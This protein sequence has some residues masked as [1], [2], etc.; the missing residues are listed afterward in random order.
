MC[1]PGART[2]E[3]SA[4]RDVPKRKGNSAIA[5]GD[6]PRALDWVENHAVPTAKETPTLK[7]VTAKVAEYAGAVMA[8]GSVG[9]S[10]CSDTSAPN[11]STYGYGGFRVLEAEKPTVIEK[12]I[13]AEKPQEA[14]TTAPASVITRAHGESPEEK[15]ARE[16]REEN[17]R[18]A[19]QKLDIAKAAAAAKERREAIRAGLPIPG[20]SSTPETAQTAERQTTATSR[21]QEGIKLSRDAERILEGV[22]HDIIRIL[23]G[24]DNRVIGAD[25]V[26]GIVAGKIRYQ[27]NRILPADAKLKIEKMDSSKRGSDVYA[28]VTETYTALKNVF[29]NSIEPVP[30]W[31][32]DPKTSGGSAGDR[33]GGSYRW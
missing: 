10:N 19:R 5:G 31:M 8:T 26:K 11:K 3:T 25:F 17:E 23:V 7:E 32:K 12:P 6:R 16:I 24:E 30:G 1:Q 13:V 29:G 9:P 21:Q 15:R 4:K 2:M 28:Y 22:R 18:Q 14:I 33:K 20:I 27:L